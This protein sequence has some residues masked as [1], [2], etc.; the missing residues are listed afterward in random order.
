MLSKKSRD[1]KKANDGVVG[2]YIKR[3]ASPQLPSTFP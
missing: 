3:E 1:L 2:K